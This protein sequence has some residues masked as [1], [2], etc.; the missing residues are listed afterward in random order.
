VVLTGTPQGEFTASYNALAPRVPFSAWTGGD[1]RKTNSEPLTKPDFFGARAS[2]L[3]AMLLEGHG[4]VHLR[5]DDIERL[6]TW[7]DTNALFYGTFKRE[8]QRRQRRGERISGPEI[9]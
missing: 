4:E 2:K 8:D 1:F 5:E 7:M 9:E 3:L 6:V